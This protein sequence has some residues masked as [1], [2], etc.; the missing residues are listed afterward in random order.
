MSVNLL[1]VMLGTKHAMR[2]MLPTGGGV[3]FNW[4]STGGMNGSRQPVGTTARR[5]PA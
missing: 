1:G 5:K 2:T 3:I 4:S